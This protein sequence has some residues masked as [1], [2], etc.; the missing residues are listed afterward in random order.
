MIII[1]IKFVQPDF[2][3]FPPPGKKWWTRL[4]KV[5][6]FI[7]SLLFGSNYQFEYLDYLPT[8]LLITTTFSLSLSLSQN[9]LH[10]TLPH[11]NREQRKEGTSSAKHFNL[12][13]IK[14]NKYNQGELYFRDPFF[15]FFFFCLTSSWC[16]IF[17]D[18]KEKCADDDSG[19]RCCYYFPLC[20]LSFFP[21]FSE[22]I[23]LD[24]FKW[25]SREKR[26]GWGLRERECGT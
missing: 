4:V 25:E 9:N 16:W 21:S 22:A 10:K 23:A 3:E 15:F 1:I 12:W 8:Y 5:A 20:F 11:Y 24:F 13:R 14:R 2:Q 6:R 19:G 18:R 7:T 26:G 17:A